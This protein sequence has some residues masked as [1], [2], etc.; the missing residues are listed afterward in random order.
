MLY[1]LLADIVATVHFILILFGLL[2]ALMIRR[3]HWLIALHLPFALW[4]CAIMFTDW[5][6]PLTPLE[7]E[8]RTLG[9]ATSFQEGFVSHYILPVIDPTGFIDNNPWLLG[10]FA[11]TCN[12]LCY[13]HLLW[14]T[15]GR[16]ARRRS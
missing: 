14:R 5:I 13:S 10:I 11:I 6:C 2:G 8:L 7:Q 15:L 3:Y 12:L 9:G 16:D 1:T 4:I